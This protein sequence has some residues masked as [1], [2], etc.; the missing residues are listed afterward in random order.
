VAQEAG[1]P[2]KTIT[3]IGRNQAKDDL[4]TEIVERIFFCTSAM[5]SPSTSSASAVRNEVTSCPSLGVPG[6]KA[7]IVA[8]VTLNTARPSPAGAEA[9]LPFIAEVQKSAG[10]NVNQTA[11][12]RAF[13]GEY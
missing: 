2:L 9:A 8:A 6:T 10:V 4:S 11:L 12:R 1:V 13:G 3:E 5:N 7:G